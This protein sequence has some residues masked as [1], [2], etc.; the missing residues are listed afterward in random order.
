M[1]RSRFVAA[2]FLIATCPAF[3]PALA[4]TGAPT[5]PTAAD[6]TVPQLLGLWQ[7]EFEGLAQRATVLLEPSVNWA[8]SF[9]GGINRE[10]ERGQVAGDVENGEFTMEESADGVRIAA[11]WLGDVVEGYCGHEIRGTRQAEGE[12]LARPFVLRRI[13]P[14]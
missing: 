4:Q 11:T 14:R 6:V 2:L 12:A 1:T 10:G 3:T 5:C 9:G 13:A 8:G 7:A